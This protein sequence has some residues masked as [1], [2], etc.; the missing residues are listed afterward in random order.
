MDHINSLL[1]KWMPSKSRI[2]VNS[3]PK[4]H[5]I[6][7]S[8]NTS[9]AADNPGIRLPREFYDIRA[10]KIV[11]RVLME[12]EYSGYHENVEYRK[13]GIG[14]I[15]GE[16][17]RKLSASS[18]RRNSR[19]TM[20]SSQNNAAPRLLLYACHDST[21]AATL[22]SLDATSRE[23]EINSWP[24]YTSSL[25]IE[26]FRDRDTAVSSG[27]DTP[28]HYVRV[29]YNDSPV[30]LAGCVNTAHHWQGG[31][32]FCTLVSQTHTIHIVEHWLKV[33]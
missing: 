26:L 1:Q 27:T 21:L 33:S 2:A 23:N 29:R 10:R 9:L 17:V 32:D 16:V 4:L 13:L 20:T 28:G 14:P 5:G 22:A 11:D 30:K 24:P 6:F 19:D 15:L 12:E 18:S 31:A 25:A 7:D 8:I 3:S